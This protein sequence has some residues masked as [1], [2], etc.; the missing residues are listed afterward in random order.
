MKK[1]K[2]GFVSLLA[3]VMMVSVVPMP[4]SAAIY[5][6]SNNTWVVQTRTSSGKTGRTMSISFSIYND[7]GQD[8]S[9]VGVRLAEVD[10]GI[11]EDEE[12]LA[13]GYVYPFEVDSTTFNIK[14]FGSIKAGATKSVSLSAKVRRDL[15]EGYYAVPIDI[16]DNDGNV[17]SGNEYVNIWITKAALEPGTDVTEENVTFVLGEGQSTPY[18]TYPNV[19][20]FGMNMRNDSDVTVYDVNVNMV[21]DAETAKFP[22]EINDAN[23]DRNF[24]RIEP[25]GV[26]ELPYSMAI[27]SDSYSGYYPIQLNITYKESSEAAEV[28]TVE[29]S[30]FVRIKNKDKEED[31]GDF[32]ENDRTKARLIVDSYETIPEKIIAGSEFELVLRMKNASD[33]VPASNILFSLE[34]EKFSESAVFSTESGSSSLVVNDLAAGDVTELRIKLLSKAGV[35]QR[36]YA[37]TI[38]EQYDSPE[39]KNA[40]EKVVIDIPV[41]QI[42]RMNT[43]TIEVMPESI[44]VGSETNVMFG[45]NNT[46]KV[47]LYNVMVDFTADSINPVNT[48]VGNIEPGKTGN[49]DAM[50]TGIAPTM[51]EGK[52]KITITYEDENGEPQEPVE[53]ELNLFVTEPM[54]MDMSMEV[55]NMDDMMMEEQ[56]FFG[57]YKGFIIAGVVLAAAAGGTAAVIIIKKKKKK[58]AEEAEAEEIEDI[59][60]EGNDDEI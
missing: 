32:N 55:G 51:D 60:E 15:P 25:D 57:K 58:A 35:D 24:E 23:Y 18:G 20:N 40:T 34:S 16:L 29:K 46:G 44:T 26:V 13:G 17:V 56:S 5:D 48:Y 54:E 6:T 12:N 14:R 59:E 49:V 30:F 4:V 7:S 41:Y 8:I 1:F 10:F 39:Y 22:F 9:N 28:K 50:L 31:M 21:L 3:A 2:K 27:R 52:V 33:D 45:I 38:N 53:K 19:M 42:A 11:M 37:I 47:I 43:G 36:S